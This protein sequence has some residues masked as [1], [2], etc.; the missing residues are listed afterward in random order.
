[1]LRFTNLAFP[2]FK[3]S[4]DDL[5]SSESPSVGVASLFYELLARAESN[6]FDVS[7][8]LF[9]RRVTD[10]ATS[11]DEQLLQFDEMLGRAEGSRI[12]ERADALDLRQ[13]LLSSFDQLKVGFVLIDEASQ[14]ARSEIVRRV[15][16]RLTELERTAS[17]P[18]TCVDARFAA[19]VTG[20]NVTDF[21]N[22]YPVL[23]DAIRALKHLERRAGLTD[24]RKH[25]DEA[26]TTYVLILVPANVDAVVDV[27]LRVVG[28][29]TELP[30]GGAHD[31]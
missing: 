7:L 23:S 5:K 24:W 25:S 26:H 27:R 11:P 21:G 13:L 14:S 31:F 10:P 29:T 6:T 30:N 22:D 17:N 4:F 8:S 1:M 19:V 28:G 16:A 2:I 18:A 15:S 3:S 9:E 20:P 12:M